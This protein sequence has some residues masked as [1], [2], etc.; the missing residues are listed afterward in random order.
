LELTSN[1]GVEI[2]NWRWAI[3]G[4]KPLDLI[5]RDAN[6]LVSLSVAVILVLPLGGF[7][8]L[9][10]DGTSSNDARIV[11]VQIQTI[12]SYAEKS[13][14]STHP[15]QARIEITDGPSPRAK[16]LHPI[17]FRTRGG[18]N[19]PADLGS[20]PVPDPLDAPFLVNDVL[21][22]DDSFIQMRPSLG[23]DDAGKL[24]A[25]FEHL[26]PGNSDV[27]LATSTDGG[28]SWTST[29]LANTSKNESCPSIAIDHSPSA[30]SE[31]RF[32][33]YEADE[34]EFA[35]SDDG[36]TWNTED[37]GGGQTW[38][39]RMMCPYV[40]SMGDFVVVVGQ[41]DGRN[42]SE[43]KLYIFYTMDGFQNTTG[44]SLGLSI[45]DYISQPRVTIIDD[46]EIFIGMDIQNRTGPDPGKWWHDSMFTHAVL[47]GDSGTDDWDYWAWGT[48]MFNTVFTSPTVEAA[49]YEVVLAQE[50]LDHAVGPPDTPPTNTSWLFCA[51]TSD[52]RLIV[53][54]SA[55]NNCTKSGPFLAFDESNKS[56]QKF[57][58]F[59][60][61]GATVHAVWL[62][63][64]S[65]NYRYSGDSGANWIGDSMT[66]DP[67]KVNE[68]GNGTAMQVWH[69]P[70]FTFASGK[71]SVVWHDNRGNGSVYFQTFG[72]VV[73]YTLDTLPSINE[74][75]VREVG[76]A[77]HFPP[78]S[79]L[80]G[81]GTTHDVECIS[82]YE[83]P[84]QERYVFSHW[85]D[86]STQNPHTITVDGVDN[87]LVCIFNAEYW[88]EMINPG[89][90][91]TP[92]SGYQPFGSKI[93]IEAFSPPAPP[94]G[95]YVWLGWTGSG[96]GSYTGPVNPCV[97]CVTMNESITQIANWQLQWNTLFD[98]VPSAGLV[99]EIAGQMYVTPQNHWLNDSESYTIFAPDTQMGGPGSRY[100]FS[101]WSDGGAQRHNVSV[102]SSG[103]EFIAYYVEVNP[104]PGPPGVSDCQLTGL[105][106]KDVMINWTLSPDD[107]A[108]E[109]DVVA[110]EI[111]HGTTYSPSGSG[112]LLLNTLSPGVTT[113]THVGAGHGDNNSYFYR[114]CAIDAIGQKSCDPQQASKYSKHL[115]PGMQLMSIPVSLSDTRI[116]RVFQTVDFERIIYYDAMAGKR[117]N[118]KTF[119]TRKPYEDLEDINHTMAV[120]IKV[121]TDSQFSVAGLVPLQTTIHLVV[122]W[123]LVGYPSFI[124]RTVSDALAGATYQNVET[125]DP[126]DPPWHLKRLNGTDFMLA[127][128]GYW[129]HVSSAFD[130]IINN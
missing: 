32:V 34:L 130:W 64:T 87:D 78:Y 88:L 24:Y 122:G 74:L 125:F 118:W 110:Y 77:W 15:T 111:Y 124:D 46:D 70:D 100:E 2:D 33:F 93:T 106:L 10:P 48:G 68:A 50:V 129:I 22:F 52:I 54:G 107:G 101:H 26:E 23:N 128:E 85:D 42:V 35:W 36:S 95:Q 25:V 91:T 53:N 126:T 96:N 37:F 123:N 114:V 61:M 11:D 127:G 51:W 117:H 97:D 116:P 16:S 83:I 12:G 98:T 81:V 80:W 56:H 49:G 90:V 73:I 6:R 82:S 9:L 109:D 99:L 86:G 104:L 72:N 3:N 43:D 112:Y 92:T 27:Y 1:N 45:V 30:G 71:P 84:N 44:Y 39:G 120:W 7:P 102:T 94:G 63:G 14:D 105:G 38:W 20:S 69:S 79:Y 67:M 17:R 21:V 8:S 18:E 119:D 28:T 103:N 13:D 4:G 31:M 66:G 75:W 65:V 108:G 19:S 55:W 29:A 41:Y 62:N 76:D 60:R 5:G 40:A 58:M 89:G 121:N 47:T 113:Y 59:Y 57:P 115:N